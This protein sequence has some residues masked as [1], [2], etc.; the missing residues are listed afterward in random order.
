MLAFEDVLGLALVL[1]LFVTSIFIVSGTTTSNRSRTR[2][3]AVMLV[4]YFVL[5]LICNLVFR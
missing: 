2:I 4:I 1:I 3:G 5:Q